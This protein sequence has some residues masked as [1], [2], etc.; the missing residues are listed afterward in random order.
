[1]VSRSN[2][3]VMDV[4][5]EPAAPRKPI[6]VKAFVKKPRTSWESGHDG[7]PV[8]VT[9]LVLLVSDLDPK[10]LRR[11]ARAALDEIP[12]DVGVLPQMEQTEFDVDGEEGQ[13][14]Y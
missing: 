9:T 14:S 7:E 1:M 5:A 6:S 13:D 3:A 4:R 10:Q 8:Q 12:V 2:S 11:L